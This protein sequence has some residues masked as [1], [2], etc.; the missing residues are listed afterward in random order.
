MR[1]MQ[2]HNETM[3]LRPMTGGI[4]STYLVCLAYSNNVYTVNNNIP[5]YKGI[6]PVEGRKKESMQR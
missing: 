2:F 4:M 1:D 6:N 3:S 5:L